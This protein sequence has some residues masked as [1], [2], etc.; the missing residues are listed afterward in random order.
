MDQGRVCQSGDIR[1]VFDRPTDPAVARILGVETVV[2]GRIEAIVGGMATLAVGSARL[3]AA[4]P[5]GLGWEVFICIRGEDVAVERGSA[6]SSGTTARNR[7]PARITALSPEGSLVRIGLDCGFPLESLVTRQAC[8][9]L[10][11]SEGDAVF[12]TLKAAAVHLI[13]HD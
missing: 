10:D 2:R 5:G 8:A 13:P 11:L 3:F 1:E 9:D 6:A 12:A 7:L 4:D